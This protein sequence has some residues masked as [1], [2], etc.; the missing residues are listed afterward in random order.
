MAATVLT[1][2]NFIDGEWRP[3]QSGATVQ[4]HNPADTR[5]LVADY[6][7][8]DSADARI[9]IAAAVRAFPAWGRLTPVARGRVL[10]RT[11]QILESRKGVLTELLTREEG[12]TLGE[13]GG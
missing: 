7:L 1:S 9:A 11:A 6:P 4:T 8:S 3:A 2:L 12:K 13:S 10:S 5:Q